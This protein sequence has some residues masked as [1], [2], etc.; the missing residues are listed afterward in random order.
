MPEQ[1][2][3]PPTNVDPER[4]AEAFA[5]HIDDRRRVDAAN[6]LSRKHQNFYETEY[7]VDA[8]AI[9][10]R[11]REYRMN[12]AKRQRKFI[13]EQVMRRA[14]NLWDAESPEDFER[15]MEQA[16]GTRAATG[17]GAEKMEASE[18]YDQGYRSGLKGSSPITDNPH[19]PGTLRHQRWSLGC[20]DAVGEPEREAPAMEASNG[21]PAPAQTEAPKKARGRARNPPA[22]APE[23]E[24][25][26]PD[27]NDPP[28]Q[29]FDLDEMPAAAEI[30]E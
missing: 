4:V 17:D 30:P 20:A 2:D 16:A 14:L 12:A 23:P 27:A 25:P 26:E 1:M 13:T 8:E 29:L 15:M 24:Q 19:A 18:A 22:P 10:E 11:Y 5:K 3:P 28:S 6:G 21:T 9:R 7:G